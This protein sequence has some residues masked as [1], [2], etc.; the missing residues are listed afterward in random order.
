MGVDDDRAPHFAAGRAGDLR[1]LWPPGCTASAT[2]T[3]LFGSLPH[4]EADYRAS[5]ARWGE[6]EEEVEEANARAGF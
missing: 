4:W 6:E 2:A 1:R 3:V 5:L